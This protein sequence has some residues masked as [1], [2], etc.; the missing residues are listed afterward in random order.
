MRLGMIRPLLVIAMAPAGCGGV[1]DADDGDA[2]TVDAG[3]SAALLS[4]LAL[5]DLE[6]DPPFDPAVTEYTTVAPFHLDDIAVTAAAPAEH[7]ISVAESAV[8]SGVP[9]DPIA[10]NLGPNVIAVEVQSFGRDTTTYL[11]SVSRGLESLGYIKAS[12]AEE[13]DQFGFAVAI[14]GDVLAIGAPGEK[15]ASTGINA[16]QN[17]NS[18]SNAG[19]VYIF[20]KTGGVW[21]Q[22]AY[23]KPLVIDLNDAF[24]RQLALDGDTLVVGSSVEDSAAIGVNG[25]ANNNAAVTSGAAWVFVRS[26]AGTWTQQA[27]LKASNTAS[28]DTF[29]DSVAISG[30]TIAVGAIGEDSAADGIGGNQLDNGAASAGA[31]YIYHRV[32]GVWSQQAYIKAS[33]SGATDLF[34]QSVALDGDTLVVG[35][36]GEDSNATGVNGNEAIDTEASAG[37]AYVFV[38]AGV[39]WSQQAYLKASNTQAGDVL[40]RSVSISGDTVVISA[41]GEDSGASEVNGNQADNGQPSAGAAYVFTR[42]SGIWSQEAYLK[43][44]NAAASDNFS[45]QVVVEGDVIAVT[46][47]AEDSAAQGFDGNQ[48]DNNAANAGSAYIFRRVD[49]QWRQTNY[50]KATVA[51]SLDNFGVACSL[52]GGRLVVGSRLEDSAAQAID[53][54]A[55]DNTA[56]A[57]GAAYVF[58]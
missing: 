23:I 10:L 21:V 55:N 47:L 45:T 30:N 20:V 31:V 46:A 32:N 8:D 3:P 49:G 28:A 57:A 44:S 25:D 16:D 29:A 56:T 11:I 36:D 41:E 14:S 52:S 12:N 48:A 43:A 39:A 17:D 50:L 19:A 51:D 37:A 27:Y 34:G 58:E 1:N 35:A 38:R 4:S 33:T 40:G 53:G 22:E 9:S 15:S 2:G 5:G 54:D 18:S 6:L 42:S 26:Q 24:G 13:V 7:F